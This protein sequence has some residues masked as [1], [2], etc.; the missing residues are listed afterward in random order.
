MQQHVV[1]AKFTKCEMIQSQS[2]S[3]YT[4]KKTNI[5]VQYS[6]RLRVSLKPCS[7]AQFALGANIHPDANL[8]PLASRSYANK[9]CPYVPRFDLKFN[10]RFLVLRRN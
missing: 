4:S 2:Y 5:E 8:H 6:D 10:T 1:L 7:Y 3:R 9:L